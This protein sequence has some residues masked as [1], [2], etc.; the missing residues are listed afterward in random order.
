MEGEIFQE[1]FGE[2]NK[3]PIV[4]LF[5]LPPPPPRLENRA[6]YEI[7]CKGVIDPG[8]PQVTIWRMCI[9]CWIPKDKHTHL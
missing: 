6:V 4:C 7:V 8:R 5:S 1:K 9:A 2:K 3:K